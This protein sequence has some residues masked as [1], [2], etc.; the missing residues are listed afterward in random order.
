MTSTASDLR[1]LERD[2]EAEPENSEFRLRLTHEYLRT[3]TGLLLFWG[4]RQVPTLVFSGPMPP[5]TPAPTVHS[6]WAVPVSLDHYLTGGDAS[7]TT[8][9]LVQNDRERTYRKIGQVT[10]VLRSEL[11]PLQPRLPEL[12]HD[13]P[14]ERMRIM[15]GEW[16]DTGV[17]RE[18]HP[19]GLARES[20][21]LVICLA[22]GRWMRPP[23]GLTS[24]S[25]ASPL[26]V[27]PGDP[28]TGPGYGFS[29]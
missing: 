28:I 22:S 20:A 21:H 29:L 19:D 2:L 17:Y 14:A 13:G 11:D 27:S 4:M 9:G 23:T 10:A 6:L 18:P 15:A 3:K 8:L 12:I 26:V 25:T 7:I 24:R 16:D 5:P 1:Q